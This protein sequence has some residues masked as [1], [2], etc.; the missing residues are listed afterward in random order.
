MKPLFG[1]IPLTLLALCLVSCGYHLGFG[2]LSSQY[3]SISVPY[4]EGDKDGSLT[5]AIIRKISESGV[6][7]YKNSNGTLSLS[8][9]VIEVSDENIGF[10]YDRN[11]K[12]KRTSTVIPTE[13][14]IKAVAEVTVFDSCNSCVLL[15]PVLIEAFV[16]FDHDYYNSRDG[17][18]IF[19]LGQLSDYDEAHDAVKAPLDE[20]LANKIVDYVNGSW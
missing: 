9:R 20:A 11:K 13:T 6:Y 8:A 18:N 1:W 4:V 3:P 2:G 15:G 5:A 17:I 16:D 14:R 7:E 19:S 10:R 12:G